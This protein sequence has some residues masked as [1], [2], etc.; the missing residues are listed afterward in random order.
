MFKKV[1]HQLSLSDVGGVQISFTQYL[2]YALKKSNF[3]HCVYS[4]HRLI[5]N[6]SDVQKYHIDINASILNKIKFLYF[7]YSKKYIIHFYNNLGSNSVNKLLK[8]IPSSNIIF[9][10]RGNAWNAE[11]DDK[12]T[13]KN[14]A[15]KANLILANSNASKTMLIE[16]FGIDKNKIRVIYN[17]F[18][19]KEDEFVAKN[20][21]RYSKKFSVGYIGRLDTPK[22]VHVLIESAKK[23]PEYD[24]FIAGVGPWENTLR[25]MAKGNENIH[26]IGM[27]KEPLEFISKMDIIIAPSIREPLGNAIIEAGYCKKPVI[28]TNIDGIAE[29]IENGVSG[30]LI[31][32]EY[33]LSFK[34]IP[35]GASPIPKIVINPKNQKFQK[36]KQIDSNKLCKFIIQLEKNPTLRKGYGEKLNQIIQEKF[37][38]EGYF[39]KLENIYQEIR[40]N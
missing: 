12:I 35:K 5:K 8:L 29:I 21:D 36:P 32:P 40:K 16:R 33:E 18:L 23:L 10:E 30:L 27:V 4:M 24:F 9:H 17:G 26:F 2:V 39:E 13:Y 1:I 22:G 14:N 37:S 28:A 25:E 3:H 11:D 7:L 6:F 19:S 38:I 15:L 31:D 20:D 34:I